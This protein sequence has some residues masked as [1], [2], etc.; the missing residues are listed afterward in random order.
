MRD[1][2]FTLIEVLASLMIFSVAIVGL[3]QLNT[4]SVNTVTS[5]ET[6]MLAGIVA[7]NVL[8]EARRKELNKGEKN[9]EEKAKGIEFLWTQNI[10][11]TEMQ[12]FYEIKVSVKDK[13]NDH[14]LIERVAYRSDAKPSGSPNGRPNDSSDGR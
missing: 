8:V 3:I 13:I 11:E 5:L 9:G 2:G 4:Q 14:L 10:V 12:G 6:K 1:D 7:D